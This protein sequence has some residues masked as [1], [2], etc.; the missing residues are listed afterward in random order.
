MSRSSSTFDIDLPHL[1]RVS[2][3]GSPTPR[4]TPD[5]GE[6][7][8]TKAF[9][10]IVITG[11]EQR[12]LE[13]IRA[14]P[15]GSRLLLSAAELEGDEVLGS[16]E[17]WVE[18]TRETVSL[19]A[20]L[21]SRLGDRVRVI[22]RSLGLR[23]VLRL[24][25][26]EVRRRAYETLVSGSLRAQIEAS[27]PKEIVV[28][29]RLLPELAHAGYVLERL[30]L[31]GVDSPS[32]VELTRETSEVSSAGAREA[33]AFRVLATLVFEE[34]ALGQALRERGIPVDLAARALI[35]LAR[36][37]TSPDVELA[38]PSSPDQDRLRS[39]LAIVLEH[40]ES[41]RLGDA[42]AAFVDPR[43][44]SARVREWLAATDPRPR[45]HGVAPEPSAS[46][47]GLRPS[48]STV[49]RSVTA[50][51]EEKALGLAALRT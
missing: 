50:R 7:A 32:L 35:G 31:A 36:Q 17:A 44:A 49:A 48:A 15:R 43:V 18:P 20:A 2:H 34:A 14:L 9:R 12:P 21:K 30:R 11:L 28:V 10:R 16:I 33:L 46:A 19:E 37:G 8:A 13:L 45:E 24:P 3:S 39:T 42:L 1:P 22:E 47:T 25:E 6:L 29:L 40:V 4:E 5:Q 51:T 26:G 38:E 23:V 27:T 41:G